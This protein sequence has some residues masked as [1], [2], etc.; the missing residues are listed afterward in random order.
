[1]IAS[2]NI[3]L[4]R[5]QT[6]RLRRTI[7][8]WPLLASFMVVT[9]I[10]SYRSL[11]PTLADRLKIAATLNRDSTLSALLGHADRFDTAAGFAAWRSI[12][13]VGLVSAMWMIAVGTRIFRGDEE[14]GRNEVAFTGVVSRRSST[15]AMLMSAIFAASSWGVGS[16]LAASV[17]RKNDYSI[18]SAGFFGLTAAIIPVFF[19]IIGALCAQL[20]STRRGAFGGGAIVF[21]SLFFLRLAAEALDAHWLRWLS[22]YGWTE[23]AEPLTGSRWLV[24]V[25]WSIVSAALVVA[26]VTLSS[27]RDY[28]VG[29]LHRERARRSNSRWLGSTLGLSMRLRQPS[30]IGWIIAT[31]VSSGLMGVLVQSEM[32][33]SD[34]SSQIEK[35][36]DRLGVGGSGVE[37]Y[38]GVYFLVLALMLC[39]AAVGF[40][41]SSRDE[42]AE[43]RLDVLLSLPVRRRLWILERVLI[44]AVLIVLLS[45][46]GGVGMWVGLELTGSTA[47]LKK[48]VEAGL[49]LAPIALFVFSFAMLLFGIRP[50]WMATA[51]YTLLGWSFLL[52]TAASITS[53]FTWIFDLSLFH[54]LRL[55]PSQPADHQTNLVFLVLSAIAIALGVTSFQRRDLVAE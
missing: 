27:M 13:F 54:Y 35:I 9:S 55:V 23:L 6:R 11:Y 52:Q 40:A 31:V 10:A 36:Y 29:V 39:V 38:S 15:T 47:S 1:M 21:V 4:F 26:T 19:V 32:S 8:V 18:M 5:L 45:V 3:A 49:N 33:I 50:R 41:S 51:T 44:H 17:M 42:E 53:S 12:G 28:G 7:V 25:V 22:P 30:A 37:R 14:H 48:F 20:F 2:A 46:A 43:G 16:F 34:T 24:L